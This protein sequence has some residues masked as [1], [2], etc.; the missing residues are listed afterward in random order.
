MSAPAPIEAEFGQSADGHI[1]AR[2]EDL[3]WLALPVAQGLRVV[4]AWRL[5]TPMDCWTRAD[6][7]SV[8]AHV[9]DEAGFRVHVET[10]AEH[11]RQVRALNR[12]AL[13]GTASTPWGR[14]QGSL[15]YAEGV[16]CHSTASHGGFH[17]VAARNQR[18]DP[19][20]RNRDGWYEED[21]EWAKV[22]L[23]FPELFTDREREGATRLLRNF[24]PDAWE[25]IHGVVLLPGESR[26]KDERQFRLDHA[27]DWIVVAA[28]RSV[29]HPGQVE[30][31]AALGGDRKAQP[32]RHFLVPSDDYDAGRFGFVIDESC[33]PPLDMAAAD[34]G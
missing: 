4:S 2:V 23:T 8:E 5:T 1:A 24:E 7:Y 32:R 30:C 6:F 9:T 34:P 14:S 15:S 20:L 17:L 26:V 25:A 16:V 10:I 29:S 31:S 33:H 13:G 19:L 12:R 21:G 11:R 27:G 3:A 22:A 28:L 18:V